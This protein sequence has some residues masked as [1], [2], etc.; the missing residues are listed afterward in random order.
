MSKQSWS[1]EE[2]K[3]VA[4][5]F[6]DNECVINKHLIETIFSNPLMKD[7]S[8]GTIRAKLYDLKKIYEGNDL[9]HVSKNTIKAFLYFKE[10]IKNPLFICFNNQTNSLSSFNYLSAN[11]P[12]NSVRRSID[13]LEDCSEMT[14]LEYLNELIERLEFYPPHVKWS[15]IYNNAE[16]NHTTA[17]EIR[18][19]KREITRIY[20]FKILIA[21]RLNN[22]D[23][24]YSLMKKSGFTFKSNEEPDDTVKMALEN[25]IYSRTFINE[26]LVERGYDPLFPQLEE[27][28][29]RA[30]DK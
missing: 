2:E 5:C 17:N 8:I 28:I 4:E 1:F 21:M 7:H 19:G 10:K 23:W 22:T 20:L 16:I 11:N 26:F 13:P 18:Q 30:R 25:K 9:S 3:I 24:S 15:T 12:F 29:R 14:F 6:F 27:Q